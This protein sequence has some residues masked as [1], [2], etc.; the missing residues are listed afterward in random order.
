[1]EQDD[2]VGRVV[3]GGA[4]TAQRWSAAPYGVRDGYLVRGVRTMERNST[5]P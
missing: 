2:D 4:E 3:S 1:M 5:G